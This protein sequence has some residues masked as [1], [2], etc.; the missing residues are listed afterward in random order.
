MKHKYIPLVTLI[1]AT[2]IAFP[3]FAETITVNVKN[4]TE[5]KNP[6]VNASTTIKVES[7][8]AEFNT[9]VVNNKVQSDIKVFTATANRLDKIVVRIQSRVAKIKAA[10]GNTVQIEASL[11]TGI[12]KLAEARI[13]ISAFSSI[14]LT[15]ATSSTTARAL[16]NIIKADAVKAKDALKASHAALIQ[17]VTLMQGVEAKTKVKIKDSNVGENQANTTASTTENKR[18]Q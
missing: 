5:D 14:D 9:N 18:N 1:T 12:S 2:L 8:Q 15:G 11:N 16:L 17:A 13:D 4:K 6:K 3:V 10:G 7:N